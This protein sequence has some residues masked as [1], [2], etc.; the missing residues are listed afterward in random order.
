MVLRTDSFRFSV[1]RLFGHVTDNMGVYE[2]VSVS[3]ML[4]FCK[5]LHHSEDIFDT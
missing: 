2:L 3:I 1:F 4:I 5:Y